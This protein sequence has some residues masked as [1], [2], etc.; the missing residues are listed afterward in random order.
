MIRGHVYEFDLEALRSAEGEE[1][2]HHDAYYTVNEAP[3]R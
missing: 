1:L 3:K 2:L